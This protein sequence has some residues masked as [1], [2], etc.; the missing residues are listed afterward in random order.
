MWYFALADGAQPTMLVR[1]ETIGWSPTEAL[2]A[3]GNVNPIPTL[4]SDCVIDGRGDE[5]TEAQGEALA[6]SWKAVASACG[7]GPSPGWR[8]QPFPS[9]IG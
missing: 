9:H 2:T 1:L 3:E 5:L 8:I 4:Y 6:A 7:V